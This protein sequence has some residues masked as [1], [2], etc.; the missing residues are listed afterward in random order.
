[1]PDSHLLSLTE[2]IILLQITYVAPH[3]IKTMIKYRPG[4]RHADR[5]KPELRLA[6]N[7]AVDTSAELRAGS[8]VFVG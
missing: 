4:P 6:E 5:T 3:F 7:T 8:A 2:S 1:M